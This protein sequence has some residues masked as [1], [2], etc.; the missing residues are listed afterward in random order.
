MLGTRIVDSSRADT[1]E[2]LNGGKA[3]VQ[4]YGAQFPDQVY[5]VTVGSESL[6]RGNFTG[7]ELADK[8]KEVK[9]AV[10]QF[11][12]GTADSWNKYADGT[13]DPVIRVADIV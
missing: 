11:K 5:A 13:A 7:D 2:G 4:T 6:Y 3:A 8:I 1:P 9:T 10:P 12:V